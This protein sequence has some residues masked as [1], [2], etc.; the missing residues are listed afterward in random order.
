MTTDPGPLDACDSLYV[1]PHADD[2]PLSCAARLLAELEAGL[3]VAILTVFGPRR[4]GAAASDSLDRLGV[5]R[6]GLELPPAAARHSSY[7]GFAELTASRHAEDDRA[8]ALA[9]HALADARNRSRARHVYV[10]LGVGA[11]VDHRL[12][13]EA[14]L[15]AFES[16]GGRNVFLY[17]DRPDAL[18]RGAVRMRLGHLGARLP[19]GAASAA[20]DTSLAA[21]LMRFHVGPTLRGDMHGLVDRARGAGAAARLWREARE[22]RP[23]KGFGPRLQP[24]LHAA[25]DAALPRV[26]AIVA[27]AA[28][29][30]RAA[31]R[32]NALAS[33]YARQ[34]GPSGHAE[35]L[36]LLLPHRAEGRLAAVT[37]AEA[38][39]AAAS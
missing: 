32:M 9:A 16:G 14:A 23:G 21:F 7:A 29:S 4:G 24:V 3:R 11:H 35:R 5:R 18:V 17:E 31:E 8:A 37:A 25:D 2:V 1:S 38:R 36:W 22:W 27:E 10:P 26:R 30:A 33:R 20:D 13:H 6:F 15:S 28:A 19:A 34:L 12:C 39:D